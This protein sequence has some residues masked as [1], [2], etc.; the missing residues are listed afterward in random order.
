MDDMG[1]IAPLIYYNMLVTT[2]P[3]GQRPPGDDFGPSLRANQDIIRQMLVAL[4]IPPPDDFTYANVVKLLD[5]T[6]E[7]SGL[8]GDDLA[9]A[10]A[11]LLRVRAICKASR[12]GFMAKTRDIGDMCKMVGE[13]VQKVFKQAAATAA[14]AS[15][16]AATAAAAAAAAIPPG[17]VPPGAG[18]PPPGTQ[19]HTLRET[20]FHGGLS[21]V[22]AQRLLT[23]P[24][25]SAE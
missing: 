15:A 4:T 19:H 20:D 16:A 23:S 1:E 17:A 21:E 9:P 11:H 12:T 13:A 10:R 2:L 5:H 14:Q 24:Y 7:L 3:E 6:G 8:S 25:V 22:D 18:A